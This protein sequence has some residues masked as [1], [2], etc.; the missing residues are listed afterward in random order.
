MKQI[1]YNY[2]VAYSCDGGQG[3]IEIF[4][5]RKMDFDCIER[6]CK[7]TIPERGNAKN[8]IV[9]NFILLG[10]KEATS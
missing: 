1:I 2:F 3:C 4:Q 9:T 8:V 5:D 10:K 6:L 7:T